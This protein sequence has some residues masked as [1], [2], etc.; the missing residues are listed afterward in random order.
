MLRRNNGFAARNLWYCQSMYTADM[1]SQFA[2]SYADAMLG[3]MNASAAAQAA[4]MRQMVDLWTGAMRSAAGGSGLGAQASPAFVPVAPWGLPALSQSPLPQWPFPQWPM[5]PLPMMN[6]AQAFLQP[7][8]WMLSMTPFGRSPVVLQMAFAMMSFGIPRDVAMP[9][10]EANAAALDAAETAA[11][12]FKSMYSA[13]RTDG[14][15]AS[16]QIVEMRRVMA[17]VMA[18]PLGSAALW[19]WLMSPRGAGFLG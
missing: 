3:Y 11:G 8:D 9:A 5:S 19:P 16:A 18:A 13:F 15:H 6:P 7:M 10:A 17:L 12:P 4:V 2:K 14:G 1:Q